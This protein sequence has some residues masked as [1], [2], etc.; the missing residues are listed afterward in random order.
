MSRP[1]FIHPNPQ[2]LSRISLESGGKA[3]VTPSMVEALRWV[4]DHE[5]NISG[6]F[7]CPDDS[8]FSA[9]RFL[10]I[11]INYR[12]AVPIYLFEPTL[13]KQDEIAKK[14]K[15]STH[16]QGFFVGTESYETLVANLKSNVDEKTPVKRGKPAPEQEQKDYTALN[17]SDFFTGTSYPYDLF[18]FTPPSKMSFFASK[19]SPIDGKYLEALSKQTDYLYALS[20]DIQE[21]KTALKEAHSKL[22]DSKDFPSSWKTAEVMAESKE[23][24]SEIKNSGATDQVVEVAQHML[25]DLFRLIN[26]I[27]TEDGSIFRLIDKAKNCDRAI[28]CASYCLLMC[29]Y[30]KFEKSATLEILGMASVLQDISLYKTPFGDLSDRSVDTMNENEQKIYFKHPTLSADIIAQHTDVP[31]ITLQVIRQAHERKDRSGFPSKIGGTQLHPMSEILSLVNEL[32]NVSKRII[33]PHAV[34]EEMAKTI[35]THYSEPIV[36]AFKAVYPREV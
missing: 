29:K 22:I 14:V 20:A 12:P 34:K 18:I 25:D 36:A 28:F 10:E 19:N 32:Y 27:D 5:E 15:S 3:R 24:L 13:Q 11:T 9:F 33:D 7:L 2:V 6:I 23:L 4:S 26:N 35:L 16:V 17:I 30:L 31:Q 1:V 21:D 8:T